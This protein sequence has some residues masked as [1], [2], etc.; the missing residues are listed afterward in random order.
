MHATVHANLVGHEGDEVG[1]ELDGPH[2][3]EAQEKEGCRWRQCV[4][5]MVHY[6]APPRQRQH[7][8]VC[9][10]VCASVNVKPV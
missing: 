10:C 1:V 3:D 7:L 6:R 2:N 4:L 9:V 8:C 5:T